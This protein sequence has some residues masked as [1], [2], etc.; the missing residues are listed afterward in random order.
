MTSGQS[1]IDTPPYICVAI[2]AWNEE[3]AIRSTLQSLLKQSL[4]E[5]LDRGGLRCEIICVAN[6]C[7]DRTAA[8]AEEVLRELQL[9]HPHRN[10]WTGRSAHLVERGKVNAWNQFVHH[11]ATQEARYL[12]M[13]DADILIHKRETMWN[14][15]ETLERDAEATVAVDIPRKDISFKKHRS[16]SERLSMN[17]S[18]MTLAADGQLCGQ[19]YCIRAAAARRIYLPKGLSACEDGL[20]KALV[21]TDFLTHAPWPKRIRVAHDAEHTF[22]AYT[23]P[24]VILRNQ[25]RQI[26]GQTIIHVLV[27]RYLQSLPL[28]ERQDLAELLQAK[29]ATD[30]SWLKNL[31]EHHLRRTR[32][33]WRLYP[34]L[35]TNRFRH[36]R[37]L[38]PV[39]R[40]ACLPA[41]LAGSCAV[42]I[43][44]F[45][46]Y[47]SLRQGCTDY[48]PKAKRLGLAQTR[49]DTDPVEHLERAPVAAGSK[50]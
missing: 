48:W 33:C 6:G 24:G 20:I 3:V 43:G 31:I 41:A 49:S 15:L 7:T 37:K 35:V 38:G 4:F 27:D 14:M 10:A 29:D 45:L 8:V 9:E 19:L 2:F 26:I 11:L 47:R 25:K 22:E 16:V 21:C 5:E 30:P 12:F 34:E 32:F 13:M 1:L 17:T 28:A 44:S 42:L 36:L 46:A 39:Q 18:R 40:L 23:N 50:L